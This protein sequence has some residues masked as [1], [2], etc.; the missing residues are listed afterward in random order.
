MASAKNSRL[1]TMVPAETARKL[2]V[3]SEPYGGDRRIGLTLA[4]DMAYVAAITQAAALAKLD[5]GAGGKKKPREA[6]C[7]ID[8]S[9]DDEGKH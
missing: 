5:P 7:K 2:D 3:I 4:I 6:S 8:P 9:D 1:N